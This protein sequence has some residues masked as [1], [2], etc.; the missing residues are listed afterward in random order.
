MPFVY[1]HGFNSDGHGSK[2]FAMQDYFHQE[3]VLSPDLPPD[4]V[5]VI[6]ILDQIHAQYTEPVYLLG[7]SLGAFYAYYY[8]SKSG[9]PVFL[10]NPTMKPY[11][12]LAKRTGNLRT[13]TNRR[14]YHFKPEYLETLKAM[15]QEADWA[16]RP[17]LLHFFLATDD[18]LLDLSGLADRFPN[19]AFL[20][21]YDNCQH[22]FARFAEVLPTIKALIAQGQTSA[23]RPR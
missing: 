2:Y 12:T 5:E 4:P 22:T 21:Y 16:Y 17:E 14:V 10:F 1:L 6:K 23:K 20:R 19:A 15:S 7:T 11:Q 18:E 9:Y 3:P 13:F 8:H